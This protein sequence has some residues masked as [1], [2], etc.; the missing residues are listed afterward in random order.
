MS[1]VAVMP[2]R[3]NDVDELT[4]VLVH[5][6]ECPF[7]SAAA[8]AL[9]RLPAVG[10]VEW[11]HEAAQSFLRAQFDDP[12]F[13]VVFV[14]ADADRV[15]VGRDA[16]VEVCA[17]AGVPALVQDVVDAA[18]DRASEAVRTATGGTR[19]PDRVH[20]TRPLAD[21]ARGPLDRLLEAADPVSYVVTD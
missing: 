12:P 10:T 5:D 6:G 13:A 9:R 4:G 21:A 7:C 17:R 8:T 11:D 15:F 20:A 3:R 16:A 1:V 14:D 18:Y 2:V 19:G